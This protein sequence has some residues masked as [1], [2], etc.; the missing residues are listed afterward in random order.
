MKKWNVKKD[1]YDVVN[2]DVVNVSVKKKLMEL[3]YYVVSIEE[4]RK[5]KRKY[6]E[7]GMNYE[8]LKGGKKW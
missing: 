2:V 7:M 8:K 1:F 5:I 4:S 6:F 3:G